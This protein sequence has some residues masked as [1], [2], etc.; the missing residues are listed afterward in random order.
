MLEG[1]TIGI[2]TV[3][4]LVGAVVAI[5]G[6]ASGKH[7]RIDTRLRKVENDLAYQSGLGTGLNK[8][9]TDESAPQVS[10]APSAPHTTRRYLF[11]Y[12]PGIPVAI[13]IAVIVIAILIQGDTAIKRDIDV[14]SVTIVAHS[15]GVDPNTWEEI[16]V[17]LAPRVSQGAAKTY[18]LDDIISCKEGYLPVAAWHEIVGS[19]P[20]HDVMYAV[21]ASVTAE[22]EIAIAVRSR[23]PTKEGDRNYWGETG[24]SYIDVLVL[25]RA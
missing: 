21:N 24:Y 14:V 25:C 2:E 19:W 17:Y 1:L 11:Q 23:N 5:V 8:G 4:A 10:P 15:P 7:D 22:G 20:S 18:I 3:I 6:I 13:G 9:E 12:V 16:P